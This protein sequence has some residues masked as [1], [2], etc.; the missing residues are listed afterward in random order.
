MSDGAGSL[1]GALARTSEFN[2]FFVFGKRQ[3]LLL[4]LL[5]LLRQWRRRVGLL[6]D[7]TSFSRCALAALG[8]ALL[9]LCR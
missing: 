9:L 2:V 3:L 8:V 4:L 1:E 5:L 7:E 6:E